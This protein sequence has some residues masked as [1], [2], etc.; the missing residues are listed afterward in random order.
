MTKTLGCIGVVMMAAVM[1]QAQDQTSSSTGPEGVTERPFAAGGTVR[2]DLAAGEY[3]IQGTSAEKVL[4][5]WRTRDSDDGRKVR[6]EVQAKDKQALIRTHGPKNGF[7]V[8]IEVPE[9]S[10]LD[11]D[12]SAGDLSVRGIKGNK[13][14]DVWAGDV[15]IEMGERDAYRSVDAAVKFGEIDA[16]PF[17]V[18]KG[19]MFR[20]FK[21]EGGGGYN[22][23]ARL[24]AGDLKLLR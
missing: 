20:S 10:D 9:R 24:F 8:R 1:L 18:S 22:L 5:R 12:L 7:E 2:F 21:W 16:R 23:R 6:I 11:L 4:V 13:R 3:R 19:G 17:D 14:V 15:S